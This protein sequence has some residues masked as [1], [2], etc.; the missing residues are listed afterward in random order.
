MDV[1]CVCISRLPSDAVHFTRWECSFEKFI[2]AMMSSFWT[3]SRTTF[4]VL[5]C[6]WGHRYAAWQLLL[7]VNHH[8]DWRS[9]IKLFSICV[10]INHVIFCK[11]YHWHLSQKPRIINSSCLISKL[12]ED[13]NYNK[14]EKLRGIILGRGYRN[15]VIYSERKFFFPL[16][17]T[18]L[19]KKNHLKKANKKR[20]RTTY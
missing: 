15:G 7:G 19:I 13:F 18:G 2:G 14:R 3:F 10:L 6:T 9:S 12:T 8:A 11:M 16:K 1:H 17:K 5:I 20:D 4:K